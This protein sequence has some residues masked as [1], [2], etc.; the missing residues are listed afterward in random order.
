MMIQNGD[1]TITGGSFDVI[2]ILHDVNTG[3]YHVAFFEEHLFPGGLDAEINQNVVRLKSKMH[4]TSGAES[5]EGALEHLE[6]MKTK[7]L[8]PEQNIWKEPREWDGEIGIVY[9]VSKDD[10]KVRS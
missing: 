5:L 2:T 9:L 8:L 6:D 7:I 4:H 3:R 1:G 10:F